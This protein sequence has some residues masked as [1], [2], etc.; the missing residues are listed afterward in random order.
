MVNPST[1]LEGGVVSAGITNGGV[2]MAVAVERPM[3]MATVAPW[4]SPGRVQ[5]TLSCDSAAGSA[6]QLRLVF[7]FAGRFRVISRPA[8]VMDSTVP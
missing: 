3:V 6:L 5:M 4:S 2:A 8:A 7:S 1:L